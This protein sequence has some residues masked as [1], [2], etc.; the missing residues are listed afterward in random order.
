MCQNKNLTRCFSKTFGKY[1]KSIPT[2]ST[3]LAEAEK[4]VQARHKVNNLER[5]ILVWTGKFKNIN[6]V[7][8]TV[9]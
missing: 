3:P 2:V 4:F 9:A 5:R 6:E 7:P 1:D 8:A